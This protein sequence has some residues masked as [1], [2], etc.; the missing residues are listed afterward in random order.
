MCTAEDRGSSTAAEPTGCEKVGNQV[1][2]CI[3]NLFYGLGK[4][5]AFRPWTTIFGTMFLAIC[6]GAGFMRIETE[7]RP[8]KLWVPQFADW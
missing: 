7:N 8:E 2:D 3:R 1:D 6:C 5:V 4:F